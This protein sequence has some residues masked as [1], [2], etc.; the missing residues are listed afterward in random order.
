[1]KNVV[2][3][4]D[5]YSTFE[6]FI[7]KGQETYYLDGAEYSDVWSVDDTWWGKLCKEFD[8]NLVLNDSWSGATV[9]YTW[10]N[11]VD[12][13]KTSSFIHRFHKLFD[14]GFFD[15]HAVDTVFIFGG[16]NDCWADVHFGKKKFSDFKR[17]DLYYVFPAIA[18]LVSEIKNRLG[19]EVVF[20][21]NDMLKPEV[22]RFIKDACNRNG[23]RYVQLKN[24]DKIN[25]H[26]SKVGMI[27]IYEQ[28]KR[29]V[30]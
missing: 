18:Y 14:Q 8:L 21:I 7:P 15:T 1:M 20:I 2:I 27:E 9:S 6:G 29:I 13:S 24:I 22:A 25:R 12:C 11:G 3:L 30:D 23:A 19:V 4:G 16:T 28:V 5:S 10:Y 17:S 26:P